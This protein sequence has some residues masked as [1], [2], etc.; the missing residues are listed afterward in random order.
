MN[1][2][3]TLIELLVVV[4]I[5]GIL[6][7]VALPQYNKAVDRSRASELY[8]IGNDIKRAMQLYYLANGAYPSSLLDLE[9]GYN[10]SNCTISGSLQYCSLPNEKIRIEFQNVAWTIRNL[11]IDV[12]L[13]GAEDYYYGCQSKGRGD[14]VCQT[15][16]GDKTP[17]KQSDGVNYYQF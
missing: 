9:L 2:G 13:L 15:I 12:A 16:T 1:K 8:V 3:F 11:Q 7:A 6:S 5:I 4:L 10:L 17:I 14:F